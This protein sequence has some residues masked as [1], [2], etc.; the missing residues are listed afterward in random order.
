MKI[1]GSV[2][3]VTGANRGIGAAMVDALVRAGARRVYAATRT[4]PPVTVDPRVVRVTLDVTDSVQ[5][6]QAARDCADV[7][8]LVNNAGIALAQ[9]L[10]APSDPTAA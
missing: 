10:L 3:L 9:P 4:S 5:V 7:S 8:L 1:A 6:E 2:A